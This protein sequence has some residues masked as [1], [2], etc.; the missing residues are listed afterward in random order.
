MKGIDYREY[1][2]ECRAVAELLRPGDGREQLF[3]VA[4]AWER[5]AAERER[6][7][8]ELVQKQ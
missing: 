7:P 1:A 5:L 8:A 4:E 6:R 2:R 3:K